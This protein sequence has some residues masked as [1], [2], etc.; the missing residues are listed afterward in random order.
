MVQ[1]LSGVSNE[2]SWSA[3]YEEFPSFSSFPTLP[4]KLASSCLSENR[5]VIFESWA[6]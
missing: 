1:K 2:A 5:Y 4:A 3:L 6:D